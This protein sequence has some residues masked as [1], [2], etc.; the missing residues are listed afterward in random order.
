MPAEDK[1][2]TLIFGGIMATLA[3]MVTAMLSKEENVW[4][5]VKVFVA[6]VCFGILATFILMSTSISETWRGIII[7][8]GSA[9]V[10]TFWPML[11]RLAISL[12]E[13]YIKK[14]SDDILPKP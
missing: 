3:A 8:S 14:K 9:F 11:G 2:Q 5:R 1:I 7:S 12:V 13:K 10:A 6:G 4:D